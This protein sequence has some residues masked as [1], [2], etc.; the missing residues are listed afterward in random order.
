MD[1]KGNNSPT[2]ILLIRDTE[3]GEM[4]AYLKTGLSLR[5]IAEKTGRSASTISREV[6]RGSVTQLDTNRREVVKYFPDTGARVY[7]ENRLHCGAPSVIM[8]SWDFLRFKQRIT[9]VP[10]VLICYCETWQIK[11]LK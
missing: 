1:E 8:K 4:S 6:K 11:V 10:I 9:A 7:Q 2:N 5:A 3:R